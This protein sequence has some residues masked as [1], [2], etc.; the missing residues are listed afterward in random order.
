MSPSSVGG[1]GV[2][3]TV[4]DV[5][6]RKPGLRAS[7]SLGT[8]YERLHDSASFAPSR[9]CS[10]A[11]PMGHLAMALGASPKAD[12]RVRTLVPMTVERQ[13]EVA[14]LLK[15]Y[16]GTLLAGL[17]DARHVETLIPPTPRRRSAGRWPRHAD[18]RTGLASSG[19]SQRE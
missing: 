4:H 5:R 18:P 6:R 19:E 17:G 15:V 16:A 12:F 7:V 1:D 9:L 10:A 13:T 3:C 11:G 8:E 14:H 2:V